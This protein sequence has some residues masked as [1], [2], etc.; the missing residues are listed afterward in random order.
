MKP[1]FIAVLG[2]LAALALAACTTVDTT[3]ISPES[4]KGPDPESNVNSS[5]VVTE[6]G[7]L[8]CPACRTAELTIVR[9]LRKELGSR[10][11]LEFKQ[12]PL[13]TIHQYSM[14]AAEA[15]ECAADQGQFW[16]FLET[17]YEKQADLN[18]DAPRKWAQELGLNMDLFDRCTQS[19]IKKKAI[20]SEFAEGRKLGVGGTPTFFV[21][22]KKVRN[23]L[24]ELR[25]AIGEAEQ[26][27]PQVRL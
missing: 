12:F 23:D 20:L 25:A 2:L 26:G 15:S 24:D 18:T 14:V 19:H 21:N 4:S 5:A 3:G 11:R 13:L 6:Y 27:I 1:P 22:G 16:P 10:F 8:Q 17:A 9:P 7:D